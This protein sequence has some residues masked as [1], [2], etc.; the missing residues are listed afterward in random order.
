MT[1]TNPLT[2][3][4]NGIADEINTADI[5]VTA[6]PYVVAGGQSGPLAFVHIRS[7]TPL[8]ADDETVEVDLD[9]VLW[10]GN[11]NDVAAQELSDDLIVGSSCIRQTL[12]AA[13]HTAWG[14]VDFTIG[15]QA[16]SS[17]LDALGGVTGW[18]YIWR[19]SATITNS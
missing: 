18:V 2:V 13:D 7:D 1:G 12:K 8:T 4:R 16:E 3:L 17:G 19:I 10:V 9:L 6:Y 11:P 14:C 15:A 5:G